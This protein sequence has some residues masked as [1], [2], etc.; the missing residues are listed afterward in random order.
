MCRILTDRGTEYCGQVDQHNYQ[1]YLAA[2]YQALPL[3]LIFFLGPNIPVQ[4]K[5]IL[6][7]VL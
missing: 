7:V 6:R 5:T 3:E 2:P 4:V 1:L